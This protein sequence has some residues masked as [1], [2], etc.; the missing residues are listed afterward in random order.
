NAI[1]LGRNVLRRCQERILVGVLRLLVRVADARG[2]DRSGSVA[3]SAVALVHAGLI[4]WGQ[5]EMRWASFDSVA[6]RGSNAPMCLGSSPPTPASSKGEPGRGRRKPSSSSRRDCKSSGGESKA[7]GFACSALTLG[8]RSHQLLRKRH[9][10]A[11]SVAGRSPQSI[12]SVS[13]TRLL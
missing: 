1:R 6:V 13:R 5:G 4:F 3:E 7:T 12:V 8:L 9:S 2:L 10:P 11:T